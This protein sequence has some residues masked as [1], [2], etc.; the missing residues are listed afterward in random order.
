MNETKTLIASN[1]AALSAFLE[2]KLEQ[3][4]Y[5]YCQFNSDS[6]PW[7]VSTRKVK[8]LTFQDK[9]VGSEADTVCSYIKSG[10][11]VRKPFLK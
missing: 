1:P 7:T 4:Y 3:E 5:I 8:A 10:L 11:D 2:N 9:V 6:F